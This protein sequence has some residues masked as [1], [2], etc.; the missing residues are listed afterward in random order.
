MSD[1][2][3]HAR[4]R[5]A[6]LAIGAAW[7]LGLR[8]ALLVLGGMLGSSDLAHAAIGALIVDLAAGRIGIAWA[9]DALTGSALTLRVVRAALISLGVVG[10]TVVI[11]SVA[12]QVSLRAG[13]P[14]AVS[15][16]SLV[17][18]SAAAIRDELLYRAIPF[19]FATRAGITRRFVLP[20]AAAM[21]LTPIL[22]SNPSVASVAL[23]FASGLLFGSIY[24]HAQGAWAAI[25][26]HAAWS[27]AIGP[28]LKGMPLEAVWKQGEV[29]EAASAGGPAAWIA[30]LVTTAA[31]LFVVPRV[32][33]IAPPSAPLEPAQSSGK[34]KHTRKAKPSD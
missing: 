2:T 9:L 27:I 25:G 12:G 23:T 17:S 6:L 34:P 3:P 18:L 29:S 5:I 11:A 10:A 15:L 4:P 16:L 32:F 7:L 19:H 13:V 24:A 22:A 14:D 31:A 8:A 21:S 30:A 33:V 26:A 28:M 20:F 1:L